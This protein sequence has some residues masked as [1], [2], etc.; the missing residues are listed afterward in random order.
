MSF[1]NYFLL[2]RNDNINNNAIWLKHTDSELY[3]NQISDILSEGSAG[4]S[5]K[6]FI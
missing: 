6:K 1:L 2:N 5:N 4:V 3:G